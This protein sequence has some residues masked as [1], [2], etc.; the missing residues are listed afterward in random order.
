MSWAQQVGSA[1]C[2]AGATVPSANISKSTAC[3]GA[4]AGN[5]NSVAGLFGINTWVLADK[6][7]DI[8]FS[9]IPGEDDGDNSILFAGVGKDAISGDWSVASFL[10][11]SDIMFTLKAGDEFAAFKMDTS[12]TSGLWT[13]IAL[14]ENAKGKAQDL[15]HASIW[16][17]NS[18][19]TTPVPLPGA[20]LLLGTAIAWVFGYEKWWRRRSAAV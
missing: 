6:S 8:D 20:L 15:S 18:Q 7:D 14:F 10:G 17:S 13:T 11:Y 3:I 5:D 19:V 2:T 4:L 16:Y 1:T 12:S 9:I